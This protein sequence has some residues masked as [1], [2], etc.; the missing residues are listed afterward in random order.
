M[1]LAKKQ[2]RSELGFTASYGLNSQTVKKPGPASSLEM[3]RIVLL[4]AV[5]VIRFVTMPTPG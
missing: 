2:H 1:N 5:S 4:N 3:Q